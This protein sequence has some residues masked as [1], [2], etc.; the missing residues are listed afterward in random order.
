MEERRGGGFCNRLAAANEATK[1]IEI[2]IRCGLKRLQNVVKNAT[3]DKKPAASMEGRR[4]G[5]R[6]RWRAQEERDSVV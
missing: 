6:A 1:N 4:D 3:I 2:K 5:T